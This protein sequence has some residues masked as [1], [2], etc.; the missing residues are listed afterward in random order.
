MGPTFRL[1]SEPEAVEGG[2]RRTVL[3]RRDAFSASRPRAQP[4]APRPARGV[5]A[6]AAPAR[7]GRLAKNTASLREARHVLQVT[8]RHP[9]SQDCPLLWTY[10]GLDGSGTCLMHQMLLGDF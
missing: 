4:D 6:P 8:C 2:R 7:S 9:R 10:F 5:A 1:Q 3:R